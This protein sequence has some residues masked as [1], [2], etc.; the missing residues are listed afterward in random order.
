MTTSL[1]DYLLPLDMVILKRLA[2]RTIVRAVRCAFDTNRESE[3]ARLVCDRYGVSALENKELRDE[4]MSSLP[5]NKSLTFCQ[6]LRIRLS[7]SEIPQAKLVK[8]F[9]GPF[10]SEKSRQLV[11]LAWPS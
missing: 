2:G 3:L 9:S 8:Y 10:T 7:E 11:E 6:A 1:V 4:L 5:K